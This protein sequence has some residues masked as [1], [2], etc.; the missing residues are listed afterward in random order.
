MSNTSTGWKPVQVNTKFRRQILQSGEK[1]MLVRVEFEAGA[2]API[3]S[4]TQEQLSYVASGSIRFTVDGVERT[5]RAGDS[6]LLPP[7]IAHGVAADEPC[8]LLDIFSPP[9]EDFL[10]TDQR[11]D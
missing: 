3:H 5:L 11:V 10:A 7:G 1:T 6:I 8:V 4:H 9:R 2:V